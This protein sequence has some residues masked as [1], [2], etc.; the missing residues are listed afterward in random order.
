VRDSAKTRTGLD[1]VASRTDNC[2]IR[3]LV[4]MACSRA[5]RIRS[6]WTAARSCTE[7][8]F[9]NR[10]APDPLKADLV[11]ST[12]ASFEAKADESVFGW[13]Y[14]RAITCPRAFR[15]QVTRD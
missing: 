6:L 9:E 13:F 4:V 12:V 8:A 10:L 15:R 11:C 2:A 14:W 5:S 7:Q 1:R 3:R